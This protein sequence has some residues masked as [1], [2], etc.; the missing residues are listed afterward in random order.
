MFDKNCDHFWSKDSVTP[1]LVLI[2][3]EN[4]KFSYLTNK[5]SA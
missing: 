2:T 3:C 5:E 4:C 1:L